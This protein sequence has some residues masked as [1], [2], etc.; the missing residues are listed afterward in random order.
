MAEVQRYKGGPK[1]PWKFTSERVDA[2][3]RSLERFWD[4]PH[5]L[6]FESWCAEEGIHMRQLYRLT[7][8]DARFAETFDRCSCVQ[9][10]RLLEGAS[11]TLKTNRG[12]NYYEINPRIA[13]LVLQSKHGYASKQEI[14]VEPKTITRYEQ[15]Q[16]AKTALE[17]SLPKHRPEKWLETILKNTTDEVTR[18][19]AESLLNQ[20]KLLTELANTGNAIVNG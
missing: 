9:A 13:A 6:Y 1:G 7:Q 19:A 18:E 3:R 17:Q 10:A 2:L 4:N 20:Q 15:I 16:A 5:S 11:R 12:S 8:Q 14:E